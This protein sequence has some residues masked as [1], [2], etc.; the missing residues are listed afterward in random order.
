MNFVV[1]GG[2]GF[3]GSH[4]AEHL[5]EQGHEVTIIDNLSAGKIE[6][7]KNVK[8]KIK[9]HKTDILDFE[10]LKNI[11]KNVDG[12]FHEA[13]LISVQGSF[14]QPDEYHRVNVAGCENIFKL[15]KEFGFKVLFATSSSVYGDVTEIP[16]KETFERNPLNPYGNTKLQDEI[17]AEKYSKEGVKIIGLRYFNVYGERQSSAYAG[18]ITKFFENISN[19]IPPVIFGDGTQIRDFVSVKDV[20]IANLKAMQSKLNFGLLN[21]GTGRSVSILELAN[22]IISLSGLSLKPTLSSPL[23]GDIKESQADI[24]LAKSQLNWEPQIQLEEGLKELLK[25]N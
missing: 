18:V 5:L 25:N 16:I 6:N 12:V 19:K 15:A 8:N 3:I 7:L 13:A 10:E 22:M 21:I 2:A 1:T 24:T 4:I 20:A 11:V 14:E 23:K 9:F 17:L